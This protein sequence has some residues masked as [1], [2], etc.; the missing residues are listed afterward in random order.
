MN[1]ELSSI[2][3]LSLEVFKILKREYNIYLSNEKIE[4]IDNLEINKFYKK[5]NNSYLPPIFFIGNTYYLNSYYNLTNIENLVPFL[6]LSSLVNN[7]NPLKVGL[8]EKELDYLY[9]KYNITGNTYFPKEKEIA[10]IVSKTILEDIPFKVIFKDTDTD[11]INYLVEEKG[12]N[13]A[14]IYYN[15]S[16]KMK[17]IKN[18]NDIFNF[19]DKLDYTSVEDYLY[20]FIG[21]K[22]K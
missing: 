10:D 21:N 20:D 4:F 3:S 16:K 18:N 22:I 7:L 15:V 6:C 17:D 9:D 14:I 8:I 19:N 11:I 12:S 1:N 5:I 13:E 2:C